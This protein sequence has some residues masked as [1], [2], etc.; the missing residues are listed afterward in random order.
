[1]ELTNAMELSLLEELVLFCMVRK[2]LAFV[3]V[4]EG[5]WHIGVTIVSSPQTYASFMR[6]LSC[7]NLWL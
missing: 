5:P 6:V 2:L 3:T 7:V 1:M 4:P